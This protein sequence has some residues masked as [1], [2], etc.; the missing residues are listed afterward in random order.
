MDAS[1]HLPDS[2]RILI[3]KNVLVK[4]RNGESLDFGV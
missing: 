2:H 3:A 1:R 4:H